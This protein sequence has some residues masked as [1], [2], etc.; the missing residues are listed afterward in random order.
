MKEKQKEVQVIGTSAVY[1]FSLIVFILSF[2]SMIYT[3]FKV[4]YFV[5][6]AIFTFLADSSGFLTFLCIVTIVISLLRRQK[7]NGLA[8][9]NFVNF[10]LLNQLYL[11]SQWQ[12][13]Y[14][15]VKKLVKELNWPNI[16]FFG[17]TIAVAGYSVYAGLKQIRKTPNQEPSVGTQEPPQTSD[18]SVFDEPGTASQP[19]NI[20]GELVAPTPGQ[21]SGPQS[22]P[23]NAP[24]SAVQPGS[25]GQSN[26]RETFSVSSVLLIACFAIIIVFGGKLLIFDVWML[27]TLPESLRVIADAL[28]ILSV[29]AAGIILAPVIY[30]I[31]HSIGKTFQPDNFRATALFALL[32]ELSFILAVVLNDGNQLPEF[33]DDFL[34]GI[35]NNSLIALPLILI[36]LFIILDIVISIIM[37]IVLGKSSRDWIT[38]TEERIMLIEQGLTL[39]V[40]N[41]IIGFI[42]LLLF[43]P[44][45]FNYIGQLLLDEDDFFPQ[46][47]IRINRLPRDKENLSSTGRTSGS[48]ESTEQEVTDEEK[49]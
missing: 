7:Q 18:D 27:A 48:M 38:K 26:D 29:L 46:E 40:C 33:L 11:N 44:D 47:K 25:P 9:L 8:I 22:T 41:L 20:E 21:V 13:V 30:K 24:N 45:F 42:N 10:V 28:P 32:L 12:A 19:P 4:D 35:V 37:K 39:F 23:P 6:S 2:G 49:K 5:L 15:L 17:A 31:F 36:T 14:E 3:I 16:I 1:V 34:N 43:I